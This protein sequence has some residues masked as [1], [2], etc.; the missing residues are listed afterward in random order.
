MAIDGRDDGG[1]G[2]KCQSILAEPFT[3]V[4]KF[5]A[6]KIDDINNTEIWARAT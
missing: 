5:C 3:S 1:G 6:D 2:V 4:Y